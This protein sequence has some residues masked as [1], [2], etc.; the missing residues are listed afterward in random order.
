M[1]AKVQIL[2]LVCFNDCSKVNAL[3]IRLNKKGIFII[4]KWIKIFIPLLVSL[5]F[6]TNHCV[7]TKLVCTCLHANDRRES[8]TKDSIHSNTLLNF[9]SFF[10]G[11]KVCIIHL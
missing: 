3:F 7:S 1:P 10:S 2:V 6:Q 4:C 5:T 11:K 9:W 8:K